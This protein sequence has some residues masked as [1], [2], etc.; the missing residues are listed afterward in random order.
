MYDIEELEHKWKKYRVKK[1]K[2]WYLFF[3]FMISI[4][5]FLFLISNGSNGSV[6]TKYVNKVKNISILPNIKKEKNITLLLN[7]PLTVIENNL[8]KLKNKED[9]DILVTLPILDKQS[10]SQTISNN[11][12]NTSK[13]NKVFL[14]IIQT[15][16]V[17]AYKDVEKRFYQS[18]EMDDALFLAKSYYKKN[19]Y[20]KAAFWALETNKLDNDLEESIFI[21]VKSKVKLGQ[22]NKGILILKAYIEKSNSIEAKNLLYKIENK[23]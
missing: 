14:D 13:K 10:L 7:K 5:A 21:F 17:M 11:K 22:K 20:K 1:R 4:P 23:N 19:N 12:D 8:Q 18:H 16:S 15:S 2:P 9:N 6:V 3:F